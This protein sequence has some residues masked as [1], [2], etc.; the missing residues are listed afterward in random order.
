LGPTAERSIRRRHEVARVFLAEIDRPLG[1]AKGE[2][3]HQVAERTNERSEL[4]IH[5]LVHWRFP[6]D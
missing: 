2:R 5:G 4:L 6:R 3:D 1:L